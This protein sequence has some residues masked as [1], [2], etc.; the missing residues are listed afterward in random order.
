VIIA[1]LYFTFMVLTLCAAFLLLRKSEERES[2]FLWL[3]VTVI[4][5]FS[6]H[7]LVA[8]LLE[9]LRIPVGLVS[10]G[11]MDAGL[12][13]FLIFR[14]VKKKTVQAYRVTLPDL[15]AFAG[16]LVLA[17]GFAYLQYG[18]ELQIHYSTI[19]PAAHLQYANDVITTR[20]VEGMFHS[21][22][23]N[24]LV[25]ETLSP[26]V[27]RDAYYKV[28]LLLE[29]LHLF[30]SGAMFY[31]LAS[32]RAKKPAAKAALLLFTAFYT[33][34]YPLNNA[35]YGFC[36]LGMGV[37]LTAMLIFAT[38]RYLA[39]KGP[40]YP[41]LIMLGCTGLVESYPLFAPVV[42]TS[43]FF[44]VNRQRMREKKLWTRETVILNL[45]L[46][47]IPCAVGLIYAFVDIFLSTGLTVAVQINK[48]GAAYRELFADFL[49]V[50]PAAVFALT[51]LWKKREDS[52]LIPMTLL[53]IFFMA[54]HLAL[55]L[56]GRGSTYYYFKNNY[57][58]WLLLF[59][60][61]SAGVSGAD[62]KEGRVLLILYSVVLLTFGVWFTGAEAKL[63][64]K[65]GLLAETQRGDSLFPVYS[66]NKLQ[67][68]AVGRRDMKKT[69]LFRYAEREVISAGITESVIPATDWEDSIW[70]QAVTGDRH[71]EFDYFYG[72]F[73]EFLDTYGDETYFT[74]LYD[75]A[76]YREGGDWFDALEVLYGNEAGF[77][78]VKR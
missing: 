51:A 53:L 29:P 31:C 75:S 52:V 68:Q 78:G 73:G 59:L 23:N 55:V 56:I 32:E 25:F 3:T 11:T 42:Y 15:L 54:A 49:P 61:G 36:Y 72:T 48:E 71:N 46:F 58:L 41:V 16:L 40:L 37:T 18:P 1:S 69:D 66:F 35:I 57:L 21:S 12:S 13:G 38:D 64:R 9:L 5:L 63:N 4:G 70:Y 50:L 20:S 17:G 77:V 39:S 7:T 65:N 27:G 43:I 62:R 74:V 6:W 10:V 14:S 44:A 28:F 33:A 24:A 47:L 8:A 30:L 26:F 60:L 34:G 45:G 22:L 2:L 19:D 67:I 76:L